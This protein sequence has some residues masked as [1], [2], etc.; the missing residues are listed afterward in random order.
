MFDWKTINT[1][2]LDMDGTLLDLHF[3]NYFWQEHLPM[4]YAEQNNMSFDDA[5][6]YINIEVAKVAGQIEWYCLDFWGEKL[7]LPITKLKREIKDKISLRPDTLPFL[8]ALKKAGKEVVLVTNAH[9]DSLSL[10]VERTALDSHI[11]RLIST[12]QYGVTK[13]SQLLWQKL[14][15]DLNF[16][17]SSTLFVDD[18]L[19]ILD[20]A[21]TFGIKHILAVA[22]P[23]LQSKVVDKEKFINYPYIT[24]YRDIIAD[25]C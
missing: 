23:D 15:A 14:Q 18:S 4:R 9:P 8:D 16:D 17:N 13:E 25:I 20:S 10:K 19:V 5:L 24:D 6:A 12:H 2:L 1:V 21:K 3:D 22:N 11:D 7:N